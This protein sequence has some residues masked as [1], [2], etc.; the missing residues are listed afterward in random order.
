MRPRS[1]SAS[2]FLLFALLTA[3]AFGQPRFNF[4]TTPGNLS[5]DVVPSHYRLSFDLD[6]DKE[7]FSGIATIAIRITRPTASFAIHAHELNAVNA[8]LTATGGQARALSVQPGKLLQSWQLAAVDGSPFE[9]GNYLLRI[10]YTG[11]V[12]AAGSGLYRVP[13][14][15]NGRPEIMLATQLEAVWARM[16]FPGFDEPAFRA[17]FEI[18]ITAP[19]AYEALSNMPRVA[20]DA[21]GGSTEHRFQPTPSM[22][23]YL[24]ALAVG[25]F[26]AM[27]GESAG[28]PLR[29]FATDG[30]QD[31]AA[32]AMAA[33]KKVFP[34]YTEY[35]GVPY[36]L[37]KLDQLA[38]PG[39]RFGAMEDW[40]L[41][42][43]VEDLLLYNP[44]TSRPDAQQRVFS[45]IAHEIAH[46]WFGNLVTAASWDE[47]W[48]NE[49]FATWMAFKAS[50]RFNPEWHEGLRRRIGVDQTM[51]GDAGPATRAIRS[52]PVSE[53]SVF[54]VFDSITYSKGGAVL[55]ML[56][57]WIG[58]GPFRQGLARYMKDRQFSN[59]TAGDLW[60]HMELASSKSVSSVASSWTDQQGFPVVQVAA[61]CNRGR[62]IVHLAQSRFSLGTQPLPPQAWKIPIVLARG[63]ERRSLLLDNSSASSTFEG[64]SSLPVLANPDGLGFYRV[65]Y[66]TATLQRLADQFQRLAP[67]QRVALFS[68][69][70]AL[71]QAGLVPMP[72]YFML[73]AAIPHVADESRSALFSLAIDHLKFLEVAT[74]GTPAQSRVRS[75]ARSLLNP[76]LTRLGW[77]PRVVEDSETSGLR[78]NLISQLAYFGDAAVIARA[79][80]L[81]DAADAK[82]ATPL[83][84]ATRFAIITAVGVGADRAHFDRL[85]ALLKSTDSEEDRRTYASALAGGRDEKL[86]ALLLSSTIAPGIAPN[87]ATRIP[88]LMADL[89]PNGALA[90]QFTLDNWAKLAAIAGMSGPARLL[91]NAAGSFN[92][93][94]R[95][96]QLIADQAQ[97]AGPDGKAL[98]ERVASRIEL[99]AHVR[100]REAAALDTFLAAWK[101]RADSGP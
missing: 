61:S 69:T 76:A 55:A 11:K 89:S 17:V 47:I 31:Q 96:K 85:L 46:Q 58:E 14:T 99:Y 73:L 74:A 64:C 66:D 57:Q 19:S 92:E 41:I 7:T 8:V 84:A 48:L 97:V 70:F 23:T 22:P 98:A 53:T 100:K 37:P 60:H 36:A 63:K 72:S 82:V 56:E 52:G 81:F 86:A 29:I 40:G 59:A 25:R 67:A 77:T 62:T 26:A 3:T 13:Y 16:V 9:A 45:I 18:S 39:V 71:A 87:I 78:S 49:A 2:L 20:S 50:T 6:P 51:I 24:V 95:A 1:A 94:A 54:D 12:Q 32:Y 68:D 75:A 15:A 30:K 83:P 28:I 34:F 5:K 101:P 27:S 35:F 44:A 10:E 43:Y 33:T 80:S 4:A 79:T 91:P 42:S 21:K 38:V 93:D 65:S 88:R 90:Y